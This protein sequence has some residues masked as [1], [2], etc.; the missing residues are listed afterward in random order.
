[1]AITHDPSPPAS[2]DQASGVRPDGSRSGRRVYD[3]AFRQRAVQ[4]VHDTARP[5]AHVARE[6]GVKEG[7]LR[8]W[9]RRDR[10]QRGLEAAAVTELPTAPDRPAPPARAIPRALPRADRTVAARSTPIQN[11]C[12]TIARFPGWAYLALLVAALAVAVPLGQ[13]DAASMVVWVDGRPVTVKSSV[14]VGD[15]LRAAHSPPRDGAL[16]AVVSHRILEPDWMPAVIRV[17]GRAV[18]RHAP[19]APED[20]VQV[21]NGRDRVEPTGVRLVPIPPDQSALPAVERQV[22]SPGTK[23]VARQTYGLRSG[24]VASSTTLRAPAPPSPVGGRV[25]ALTFDDGP[26]PTWTPQV[27]HVLAQAG[28]P[29]TFCEI[30]WEIAAY[31]ALTQAIHAQGDALCDHTQTHP[32]L[33]RLPAAQITAQLAGPAQLIQ[34]VTGSPPAFARPPGGAMSPAVITVAHQSGLRLLLW[35]VDPSDYLRPASSTV[36]ARVLGSVNPGG[37]ILLH[38]GGGDRSHTVQALPIIINALRAQGYTF[39]LPPTS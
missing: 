36:V 12:K 26:D 27:L 17:D 6:L 2:P 13:H 21:R 29:A 18:S 9:V 30:G 28:V 7:T 24:E 22:W 10:L 35:S 16:L 4:L 11:L 14:R 23:G 8:Q 31:P 32:D 3:P 19:L 38:D 5:M 1:M 15:A 20:D 37:I 25:V 34:S 33:S 39:V